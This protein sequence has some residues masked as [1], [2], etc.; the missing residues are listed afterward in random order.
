MAANPKV[1]L[2]F[3][4]PEKRNWPVL[5]AFWIFVVCALGV[6]AWLWHKS[7]KMHALDCDTTAGTGTLTSWGGCHDAP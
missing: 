1:P 4:K 7:P 5:I 6:G 2:R 3:G